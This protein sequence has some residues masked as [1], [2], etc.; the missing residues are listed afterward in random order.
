MDHNGVNTLILGEIA[1]AIIK[2]KAKFVTFSGDLVLGSKNDAEVESQLKTWLGVM[3][4]VYN[5]GIKVFAVRGNHESYSQHPT[6]PWL[7]VMAGKY[8]MPNNGPKGE[9]DLTFSVVYK[10]ALIVGFDQFQ[11]DKARVNQPWLDSVLKKNP[12]QHLF[13]MAHE[14]AFRAGEHTDN[15]DNDAPARDKFWHSLANAGGR[16]YFSGHDHLY[17]HTAF[18]APGWPAN[19]SIH[20]YVLGTAGAPFYHKNDHD[21]ANGDWLQTPIKHI[22]DEFGYAVV[23]V[24]GP[25]VTITFKTRKSPGVYTAA[26]TWSYIVPIRAAAK[27]KTS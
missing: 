10:N 22:E 2:E 4:P 19:K 26:D 1:S 16:T 27:K 25:K 12:K 11:T 9:K 17:D 24:D 8:A 20:Q 18:S 5:A 23:D 6:E 7:K 13:V 21:G 14:M 15:M 3:Q